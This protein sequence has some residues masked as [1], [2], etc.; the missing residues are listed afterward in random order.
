MLKGMERGRGIFMFFLST[1]RTLN[2][3]Q[4]QDFPLSMPL[5]MERGKG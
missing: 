3:T 2:Q 5:S 1:A 4:F